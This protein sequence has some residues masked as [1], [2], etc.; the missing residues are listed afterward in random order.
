[1]DAPTKPRCIRHPDDPEAD[2]C[3][4]CGAFACDACLKF[5]EH[6]YLC[7]DCVGRE[8]AALPHLESRAGPANAL[9][10]V[11]AGFDVLRFF[12]GG[13]G[14]GFAGSLPEFAYIVSGV[15]FLR[16]YSLAVSLAN[17]LGVGPGATPSSATVAWFLPF[18][19]WV[20]PF[21][22]ARMMLR[23]LNRPTRLI[24]VWQLGY[25]GSNI[26]A[27]AL[28]RAESNSLAL[29]FLVVDFIAALSARKVVA[30]LT[31]AISERRTPS[32]APQP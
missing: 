23:Q 22:H 28:F 12:A 2:D 3:D 21:E 11:C 5:F 18:V 1:M 27:I 24:D 13:G 29:G 19:G 17:R 20:Q 6:K 32:A 31:A 7:V 25:V 30:L 14:S 9:L 4:R 8:L 16:W 26:L 15:V 10:I